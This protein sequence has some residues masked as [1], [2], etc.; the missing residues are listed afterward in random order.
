MLRPLC[1]GPVEPPPPLSTPADAHIDGQ[2]TQG[3]DLD[4]G[5][6]VIPRRTSPPQTVSHSTFLLGEVKQGI[7]LKLVEISSEKARVT[8]RV[9]YTCSSCVACKVLTPDSETPLGKDP[10]G[11]GT[12]QLTLLSCSRNYSTSD[13]DGAYAFCQD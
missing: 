8:L 10:F 5:Y 7:T 2:N 12:F 1:K 4:L 13:R 6:L 11:S 3:P 9:P